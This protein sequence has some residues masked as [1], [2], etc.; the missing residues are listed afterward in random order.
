MNYPQNEAKM[1]NVDKPAQE[2]T[3]H[4]SRPFS[5]VRQLTNSIQYSKQKH[6]GQWHCSS[7]RRLT[8]KSNKI[9]KWSQDLMERNQEFLDF[10]SLGKKNSWTPAHNLVG[11]GLFC[12]LL[13]LFFLQQLWI[14][15]AKK[16]G[17]SSLKQLRILLNISF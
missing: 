7:S 5:S 6:I 13:L 14:I 1:S 9:A 11:S 16:Y 10:L 12:V 15:R 2:L 3:V 8:R 4:R 17:P